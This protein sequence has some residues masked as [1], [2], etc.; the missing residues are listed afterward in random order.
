[1]AEDKTGQ[2]PAVGV[3]V[4]IIKQGKGL[5]AMRK[6]AHGV[7]EYAFPGGHVEWMESFEKCARREVREECGLEIDNVRFSFL[8]N[9]KKYAPKHYVH[10]GLVADWLAGEPETLEPKKAGEWKWYDLDRLPEPLFEMTR[11][12]LEAEKTGKNY[13]DAP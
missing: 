9:V 12:A 11:L 10:V 7:G 8:A 3:G 2:R 5:L 1:M 6:G 4:M 13:F